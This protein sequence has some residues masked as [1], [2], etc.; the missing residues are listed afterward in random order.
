M[1]KLSVIIALLLLTSVCAWAVTP[2]ANYYYDWEPI[3][4]STT[5]V[6]LS[7]A[8]VKNLAPSTGTG[9]VQAEVIISVA[10]NNIRWLKNGDDPTA[11]TGALL[12]AGAYVILDN[13]YDAANFK[14]IRD[15]GASGD[16][17]ITVQYR[18]IR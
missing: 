18:A 3:T 6:G 5:A 8:K 9:G 11:T 16:A 2:P 4:V 10:S 1:K 12:V 7:T 15:T 13:Y 17:I 14:A